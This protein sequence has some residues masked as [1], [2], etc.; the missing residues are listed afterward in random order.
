MA[1]K[2]KSAGC[3]ASNETLNIMKS[4]F[5]FLKLFMPETLVKRVL[6]IIL[7]SAGLENSRVTE[8]IG[9]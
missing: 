7:T 9:Y 4:V 8:L 1:Q 2:D 6:S 3:D 5:T